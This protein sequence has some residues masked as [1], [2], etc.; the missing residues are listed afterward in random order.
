MP[1]RGNLPASHTD[2][3]RMPDDGKLVCV[4]VITAHR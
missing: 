2:S 1:K 4:L 3:D